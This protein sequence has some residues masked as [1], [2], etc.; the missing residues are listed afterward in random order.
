MF[1][2]GIKALL[3]RRLTTV[4]GA[5]LKVVD[6]GNKK[7]GPP[8]RESNCKPELLR[9]RWGWLAWTAV[10]KLSCFVSQEI[11]TKIL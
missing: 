11:E 3:A 5:V 10:N 1:R 8:A 9:L 7:A 2:L 4:V 6:R